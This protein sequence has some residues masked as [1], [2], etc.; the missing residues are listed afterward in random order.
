MVNRATYTIKTQITAFYEVIR[1][2]REY[3]HTYTAHTHTHAYARGST[4]PPPIAGHHHQPPP[5]TRNPFLRL[6]ADEKKT[7]HPFCVL[8]PGT[9]RFL[10]SV[11]FCVPSII[12]Y[13][14]FNI[15]FC[16]GVFIVFCEHI[17][18][19]VDVNFCLVC[20]QMVVFEE[21]HPHDWIYLPIIHI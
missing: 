16:D 4:A 17:R 18:L 19:V 7:D 1:L 21:E 15:L 8:H 14:R 20:I 2:F 5:K 6:S 9:I 12:D 11:S 3:P 13:N 10:R